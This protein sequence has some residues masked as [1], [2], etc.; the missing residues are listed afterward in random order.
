MG[1]VWVGPAGGSAPDPPRRPRCR[2]GRGRGRGGCPV[3]RRTCRPTGVRAG[4]ARS[5]RVP[6][7][8]CWTGSPTR[9]GVAALVAAMQPPELPPEGRTGCRDRRPLRRTGPW[10]R[11]PGCGAVDR[12]GV[13]AVHTGTPFRVAFTGFAPGFGYLSG[14]PAARHVPR[15]AT[16]RTRVPAGSVGLAGGVVRGLPDRV[17]GRLAADRHDVARD[18]RPPTR[19]AAPSCAPGARVRFRNIDGAP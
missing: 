16:P 6:G 5:S 19:P 3:V 1:T 13:I 17:T 15:R 8:C 18:V 2:A 12:A 4:C 11:S 10:V 7:P 14:L 9:P